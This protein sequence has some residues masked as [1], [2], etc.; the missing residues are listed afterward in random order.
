VD[1]I[2]HSLT[3]AALARAGLAR[4][5]PLATATL[6]LAAN[7]PDIDALSYARGGS[8][9]ALAFRRGITHGP[10]A[11]LVLPIVVAAVI[12]AYDRWWRRRRRR[13][14]APARAAPV[15]GLAFLGAATHAPLDWMNTYGIRLLMPFSER[16]FYGDALFIIDPW[17][18]L[19]L[20]VPVAVA[21]T[22]VRGRRWLGALAVG[23]SL[24]VLFAPQV[25]LGA[26]ILWVF[27]LVAAGV[28]VARAW[29]GAGR[30]DALEGAGVD[31]AA[32]ATG[33]VGAADAAGPGLTR[34]ARLA[35]AAE[36]PALIALVAITLYI[37]AMVGADRAAHGE[38]LR[39]TRSAGIEAVDIMVA[40]VAANP[41]AGDIVVATPD[42][43]HLG[44]LDW[45]AS[46]RVSWQQQPIPHGARTPAVL[47]T[48]QLQEVRDFLRW[49]RF[50]YVEERETDG[51]RMVRFGDARY[52]GRMRGGLA[53]IT[54]Q[55]EGGRA[56]PLAP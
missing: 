38:A 25:P 39:A 51:G 55:V 22:S 11:M 12:L 14:A 9:A 48:L 37:A 36:R 6:V 40:P 45:L 34:P 24:M 35:M 44:R 47:A 49:S 42:A 30:A 46:P 43:Y 19:V 8:Y 29:H 7:A 1:P 10:L 28:Y 20:A 17:V 5:T 18:W 54:V 21:A 3:G 2:T 13:D 52:P 4:A 41:L 26:R 16:W 50:P 31:G 56:R 32:N 33:V 23:A 53:G 27:A 15:L